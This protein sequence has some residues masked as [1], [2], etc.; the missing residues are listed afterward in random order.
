MTAQRYTVVPGR[1]G[2]H[3]LL[4]ETG[5]VRGEATSLDLIPDLIAAKHMA[6]ILAANCANVGLLIENQARYQCAEDEFDQFGD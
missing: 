4:D 6:A 5:T 1:H 2:R 3:V